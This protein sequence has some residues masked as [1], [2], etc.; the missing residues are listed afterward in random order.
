[1]VKK[2]FEFMNKNKINYVV[3]RGYDSKS[4]NSGKDLDILITKEDYEKFRKDFPKTKRVVDFYIG[5]EE[6]KGFTIVPK[7]ALDRKIFDKKLGFFVLSESDLKRMKYFR[8]IIH[9]V[10][11][12]KQKF[13]M[14]E[15]KEKS[16]SGVF[17]R[18]LKMFGFRYVFWD[19]FYQIFREIYNKTSKKK[20]K[21]KQEK[22]NLIKK[23]V[24]DYHM[25]I[26]KN[27]LGI[28]RDLLLK[29]T[30]EEVSVGIIK[31]FLMPGE[32]V[33]E[34]GANIGYYTI[35]GSKLVGNKG[36]VYA[37][38]PI[39]ENFELL[40][41]NIA[42]NKL[43][44]VKT[45]NIGFSNMKGNLNINVNPEGNL[46]TPAEVG[47]ISR[48]DVVKCE[49]LD[50]FLRGKRKPDFMRMDI[51]GYEDVIFSGGE[52]TLESLRGIFV[53]LHFPLIGE[54]RMINLLRKLKEKGF[55][56]HKA[57]ME[58][59]RLEDESTWLGKIVNWLYKKRSKPVVYENMSI[60]NLIK[61]KDFLQGHLSL[62]IFFVK[63]NSGR[64]SF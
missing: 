57:I 47:K 32:V 14:Y 51:E 49:T 33:L 21:Q 26:D 4:K 20:L 11:V 7:S 27:G 10:R 24:N 13:G 31:N 40:E 44:N 1:M 9:K 62:E 61:N 2:L 50:G 23:K 41:K 12:V 22:K 38:E 52:K 29:G 56:I 48:V 39:K 18:N 37:V 16:A 17:S 63:K 45:F 36:V 55:E 64:A 28:H 30:R 42:L 25:Y 34:A 43:K 8:K 5:K 53:E 54:Q 46:N 19:V 35:L 59:E 6:K 3:L 15:N 58:W 60:D